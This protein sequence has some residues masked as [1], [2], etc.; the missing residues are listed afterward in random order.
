MTDGTNRVMVDI[1]TVGTDLDSA[2]VSIGAVEFDR[3]GIYDTFEVGIDL[4]SAQE[5]G[6]TIDA[7]TL[8]EFWLEQ[9]DEVQAQLHGGIQLADG[10]SQFVM[11]M[12][13]CDPD[14]FWANSPAFDCVILKHAL[15][16]VGLEVPWDYY[17]QRDFRTLNSLALDR[18]G[19]L[20]TPEGVEHTA[21]ADA[22]HQARIAAYY[23]SRIEEDG[24]E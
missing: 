19:V 3:H 18:P 22:T 2:I 21:L 5:E 24:D 23:L 13:E 17:Q 7:N 14:E 10:L 12:D 8:T 20:E 11:W 1:E 15:D 16:V 6:L 9:D 4:E